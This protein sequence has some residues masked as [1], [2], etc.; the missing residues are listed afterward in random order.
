MILQAVLKNEAVEVD[1]NEHGT[2]FAMDFHTL[3]LKGTV[4]IRTAWI[5]DIGEDI[6]RLTSCY[7]KG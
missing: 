6:P 1:A 5:I 7:V 4:T 2:R 3:G